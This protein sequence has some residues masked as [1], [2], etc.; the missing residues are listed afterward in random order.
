MKRSK[1]IPLALLGAAL[2]A[3]LLAAC[4]AEPMSAAVATQ[5]SAEKSKVSIV[6]KSMTS[7]FFRSVYAGAEAAAAEYNLT[8]DISGPD[9]E[10]DYEAQDRIIQTAVERGAQA[11]VLSAVDYEKN[12]AAV[13]EAA[14]AGVKIVTID[15]RVNASAVSTYIGTDNY[16]AGK[17]AVQAALECKYDTLHVG[18][19]N[20]DIN[21]ANGQERERGVRDALENEENAAI[22]A[23]INVVAN[24][25]SAQAGTAA[26][27]R[28]HPEINVLI[29]FNEPTSVGAAR[30]VSELGLGSDTWL[31]G[32]DSNRETSD[33]LQT[34]EVDAL[35]EQNPYA[36]GYL[37]V[38][39][40]YKLISGQGNELKATVDTST[41]IVG[42]ENMF[43]IDSQK[44]L[45]AFG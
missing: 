5:Q 6:G 30:A 42:R 14:K 15:S 9:T 40:A 45:F 21:S 36:M 35:I 18:L 31:I 17:M 39:S 43:T 8:I 2:A 44:A 3:G 27:L 28:E 41:M 22:S 1:R 29:A 10:E 26:M 16:A 34:G 4:A 20:Y 33:M 37:G 32:F 23:T 38:E 24:A 12:A 11:L 19:V 13:A 25:E 7:E